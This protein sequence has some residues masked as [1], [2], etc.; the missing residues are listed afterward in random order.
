METLNVEVAQEELKKL[1][2]EATTQQ[3]KY[4]ITSDHGNV[5][6]LSE[7]SYK[8]LLVALEMFSTPFFFENLQ[9][10]LGNS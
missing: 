8:N 10:S 4:L 1:I 3:S 9:E 2:E 5:V 6:L 7:E